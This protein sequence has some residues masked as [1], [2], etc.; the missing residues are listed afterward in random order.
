MESCV[1]LS[2]KIKKERVKKPSRVRGFF[3]EFR[4]FAIKGSMTDMAVGIIVGSAFTAFVNSLVTNVATPLIGV[5][6][7]VDFKDWMVV[8][9]RFYGNAEPTVLYIGVFLNSLISF[10][11]I[12]FVV[13]LFIKAL[14]KL[15]H[16]QEEP[17]APPPGKEEVLLTEIRDLLKEQNSKQQ[18]T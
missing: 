8:L 7:G 1:F 18:G 10:V 11:I 3:V 6:I 13:F 5:L 4:T 12:A 14:N 16:K 2:A 17:S 15:R 9:P